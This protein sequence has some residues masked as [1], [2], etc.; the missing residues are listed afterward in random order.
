ML[1]PAYQ[2]D[3]APEKYAYHIIITFFVID[4]MLT[5]VCVVR[6]HCCFANWI[7]PTFIPLLHFQ[8]FQN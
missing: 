4:S 7:N 3:V 1:G 8:E 5:A 2:S 6:S